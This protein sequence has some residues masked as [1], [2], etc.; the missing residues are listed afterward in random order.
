M[1]SRALQSVYLP[2]P[3]AGW[4]R[5][6]S[7]HVQQVGKRLYFEPQVTWMTPKRQN[8]RNCTLHGVPS[9]EDQG[10]AEITR[11]PNP[12]VH[13]LSPSDGSSALTHTHTHTHTH[14]YTYTDSPSFPGPLTR[15]LKREPW[16]GQSHWDYVIQ[17]SG[18]SGTWSPWY[19]L[20]ESGRTNSWAT[21]HQD[22]KVII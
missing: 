5:R 13:P 17:G 6:V 22:L 2:Y 11:K 16:W 14:P 3:A 21:C 4:M 15:K 18:V 1:S 19:N 7:F 20:R 12:D 8:N 10:W 9:P